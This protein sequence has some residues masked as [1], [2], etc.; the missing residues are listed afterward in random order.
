M[1]HSLQNKLFTLVR[2]WPLVVGA[3]AAFACGPPDVPIPP[4]GT[5][6]FSMAF[7]RYTLDNGLEIVLHED[8]SDPIVAIATLVHV[9]SSRE[10]EG[11]TG[12]AHFFE[13]MSFNDSENVPRGANRQLIPELGGTRNGGT[14]SDMTIYY[15]VVPT[16]ALEKILWIDSD[17]LGYMINTVTEA[18]LEREKQVVKNEKRQRVDNVPYGHTEM[19]QR[20]ALYPPEHPYHWTVIGDFDDLQS[21]TLSDVQSFYT[22]L[23]GAN[24]ATLVIAGDIDLPDTKRLIDYWFG[25]IRRG[26]EARA[27]Y[28]QPVYLDTS[29]SLVHEDNFATRPELQIVFPTVEQFHPDQYPLDLL[30]NLLAGSKEA[31]LYETLVQE[32]QLAPDV[33]VAHRTAEIAGDLVIRVRAA[34]GTDLDDVKAA[35]EAGLARFEREGINAT[36]LQRVKVQ[37]E[38]ALHDRVGNVLNKAFLLAE[39]NAF[40]NDPDYLSTVA[41]HTF[42]VTASDVVDVY[43]RYVKNAT[44]ITTSFVPRGTPNLAVEG[45]SP[46]SVVEE[47]IVQDA[48]A[49]VS[50]GEEARYYRTRTEADRSEPPLGEPPL[51]RTPSVWRTELANGLQLYGIET[52]EEA[53]VTFDLTLPGGQ[54]L[55]PPGRTGVASLLA[56]LLKEGTSRRTPV[57]FEEILDLLGARI[58]ITAG[59]ESIRLSGSTLART[60]ESTMALVEELLLQPRWDHEEF[61]RLQRELASRLRDRTGN[62]TALATD[63]FYRII[64]GSQHAFATPPFGTPQTT[65]TIE[66]DDLQTYFEQHVSPNG[67]SFH[68][69]GAVSQNRVEAAL[70]G[71]AEHWRGN[72]PDIPEQ[73]APPP[74]SEPRIYFIDVPDA[75]QSVLQVGRLAVSAADPS[76]T[77]LAFANER[78]GG[79]SSGRLFQLLRIEKGYT[80]GAR[81]RLPETIEVGPWIAR[82]SVR[83]NVT[84]ESLQLLREQIQQYADSFT[85]GD[86]DITRNQIIKGNS[87]AFESLDAKVELLRQISQRNLPTDVLEREQD[88]LLAMTLDDF[89]SVITTY[90]DES[91]MIYVVVGD[92]ETQLDRLVE[93]GYGAPVV[94]TPSEASYR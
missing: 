20:A 88:I 78:L 93:L 36:A 45:A 67:A 43:E 24:N 18:A 69:A 89:R 30:A 14:N 44:T 91:Q 81:S 83:S 50:P 94:V 21:A 15:E 26:P 49:A 3:L 16:D 27:P 22:R 60:F 35:I 70:A 46:A 37:A 40:A 64:Y 62:P 41:K 86:V 80:Y 10:R 61:A 29:K 28:P 65:A 25:E 63:A 58:D 84:L 7:E 48:E 47:D 77:R 11:R 82:T 12:F 39:F 1:I 90:L 17:R 4:A 76:Y 59:R 66:L 85:Q 71:L 38:R 51:V 74:I 53:L 42:A 87:R 54:R 19:V 34:A 5:S 73:P 32:Q 52:T 55:D 31:P 6:D 2:T 75:K 8:H 13:H 92:A 9:G 72:R 23:Y 33:T 57:E 68:I 56:T 79:S